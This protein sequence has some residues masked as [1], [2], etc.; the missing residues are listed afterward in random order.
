MSYI[1]IYRIFAIIIALSITTLTMSGCFN[2]E[3]ETYLKI[4]KCI[5]AADHLDDQELSEAVN[6]KI[7][8]DKIQLNL[9]SRERMELAQEL[10][11]EITPA[12]SSTKIGYALKIAHKWRESGFCKES[13]TQFRAFV[14]KTAEIYSKPLNSPNEPESCEKYIG[15]KK[16]TNYPYA[17]DYRSSTEKALS[18]TILNSTVL[19]KDY[20][21]EFVRNEIL[22]GG[23]YKIAD[24]IEASCQNHGNL[25]ESIK[26]IEEIEKTRSPRSIAINEFLKRISDTHDCGEFRE[27]YCQPK[28]MEQVVLKLSQESHSCDRDEISGPECN[29]DV[30][31][32]IHKEFISLERVALNKWKS[33]YEDRVSGRGAYRPTTHSYSAPSTPCR[34]MASFQLGLRGDA[35]AEY[36]H[37]V[38]NAQNR[39]EYIAANKDLLE[40]VNSRIAEIAPDNSE[41]IQVDGI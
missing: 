20:Q 38:C 33:D 3:K 16:F 22:N 8:S 40:R 35:W 32:S 24:K 17:K 5:K 2:K 6:F 25:A 9:N 41:D 11:D 37:T 13:L 27:I 26:N 12:G 15:L 23:L 10:S 28:L 31:G 14:K 39:K 21:K 19:L 34:N 7:S 1:K 18:E 30:K 29:S 4:G 36:V